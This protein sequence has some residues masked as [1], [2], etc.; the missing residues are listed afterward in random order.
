MKSAMLVQR[1]L[2]GAQRRSALAWL[3]LPL[4]AVYALLWWLRCGLWRLSGRQAQRLPVPVIV[5]GNVV[6]GG[7]GKTPATLAIL[8]HLQQ[9]GWRPG[10]VSR[11]YGRSAKGTVEVTPETLAEHCGDE[12]LLIHQHTGVPVVVDA[13]RVRAACA[14]LQ[15]HPE[16]DV[17]VC[18]DGLQ[19]WRLPRDVAVVVFDERGCGNGW[20]LPSGLLREPWPVRH[21][22]APHLVLRQ[23]NGSPATIDSA[24][25]PVFDARR[26][27]AQH[28]HNLLGDT[29]PLQHWANATCA[30]ITGIAQ[31]ASLVSMLHAAGLRPQRTLALADHASTSAWLA[32]LHTVGG[33]V[34]CTEKD[35]VKLRGTLSPADAARV[36]VLRL[37]L[38]ADPA[39]FSA[40]RARLAAGTRV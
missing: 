32:A 14:V 25:L 2:A 7:A 5:V 28:S 21:Q 34:L 9:Q 1:W 40:I 15:A 29:R 17:L 13:D 3:L 12:P 4:T 23:H 36:W 38:D 10:V 35:A 19:H 31:P 37:E 22:F 8:Q 30:V 16:V 39:F 18:D 33:D 27:L 20:L 11:G 6:V 24:G 26:Q